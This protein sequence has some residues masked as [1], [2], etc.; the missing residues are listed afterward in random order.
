MGYMR[1][2]MGKNLLGKN[3]NWTK[4]LLCEYEKNIKTYALIPSLTLS[5]LI[6]EIHFQIPFLYIRY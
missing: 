1:L 6:F 3:C 4:P 5:L 2:E